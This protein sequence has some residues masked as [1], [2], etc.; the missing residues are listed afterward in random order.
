MKHRLTA[1]LAI[2][3]LATPA[4]SQTMLDKLI[5]RI[6]KPKATATATRPDPSAAVEAAATASTAFPLDVA[7]VR[8]GMTPDEARAALTRAGYRP[9]DN[10]SLRYGPSFA[11]RVRQEAERRRT[12]RYVAALTTDQVVTRIAMTGPSRESIAVDLDAVTTGSSV[13]TG[14]DV[15]VP[16]DV[17]T[18]PALLRQAV[19]KY[20]P[21]DGRGDSGLLLAWCS[22]SVKAVCGSISPFVVQYRSLPNLR[23]ATALS[24]RSITLSE[25]TERGGR[26][27]R[28][29]AAAVDRVAPKSDRVAF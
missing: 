18:G 10:D 5:Q 23:A 6:T 3:A 13:V 9:T 28:E 14:V 15:N 29:F 24:S 25:G 8:L 1:A 7:G 27:D 16:A 17:M 19:A 4:T 12:G 11:S 26:R 2:V 22:A 20:G 21:P